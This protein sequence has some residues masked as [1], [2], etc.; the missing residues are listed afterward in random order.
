MYTVDAPIQSWVADHQNEI[1][2]DILSQCEAKLNDNDG[3]YRIDVALL[4]TENG[5]T[6]FIIKDAPGVIESL[7]R[8]MNYFAESERYESAARARDCIKAWKE[9]V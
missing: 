2:S 1:F 9:L 6:K 7:E 5:V 3:T 4:K 8:A